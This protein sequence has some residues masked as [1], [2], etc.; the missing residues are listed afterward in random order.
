MIS[1]DSFWAMGGSPEW[2]IMPEREEEGIHED[3][4]GIIFR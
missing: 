3:S 2:Q 1:V 4:V